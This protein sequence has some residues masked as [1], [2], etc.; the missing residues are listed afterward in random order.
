[1]A[2]NAPTG[3]AYNVDWIVSN[4]SDIHATNNR[5]WFTAYTPFETTF[6]TIYTKEHSVKALGI[7]EV[8][9]NVRLYKQKKGNKPNSKI[10]VLKDVLYAPSLTCNI[11]ATPV[12]SEHS[13]NF[14][15][16]GGYLTDG[17]GKR[18]ALIETLVL[19]RLRL[20]GQPA[21][22]SSLDPNTMYLMN[23]SW[24][25][26]ER[27]RW[28]RQNP[29][30]TAPSLGEAPYTEEENAWLNKHYDG[31]FK[32]LRTLGLSIHK[33]EDREEGRL[34]AR[35]FMEDDAKTQTSSTSQASKQPTVDV[36][37]ID[38]ND[39]TSDDDDDGDTFLQELEDDPMSHLAD[40]NFSAKELKWIKKNYK[41]SSRF[42]L[43]YRLKPF[44]QEDCNTA[45]EL[46]KSLM[47][48]P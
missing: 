10:L 17:D 34:I 40:Y 48:G 38:P 9:L 36:E 46:I 47:A 22:K 14:V 33:E 28:E 13:L 7:G 16:G 35:G 42:M 18:A 45:K 15:G 37:M 29:N 24:S 23:A 31:E 21:G 25:A 27:A 3:E 2:P 8:H 11:L 39:E 41:Y 1:M 30:R 12:L 20:H 19:P 43:S 5:D 26:P 4:T 44:E 32:F 6:G